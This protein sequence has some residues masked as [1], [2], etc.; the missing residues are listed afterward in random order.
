M[1]NDA[2]PTSAQVLAAA[3]GDPTHPAEP[4]DSERAGTIASPALLWIY[5]E[6]MAR[7]RISRSVKGWSSPMGVSLGKPWFGL[8]PA[9]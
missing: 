5:P 9:G 7:D 3:N 6:K 8:T 2:L 4:H 1:S